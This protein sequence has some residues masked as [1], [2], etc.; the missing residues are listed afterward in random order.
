M[1]TFDDTGKLRSEKR[2]ERKTSEIAD[3]TRK[4]KKR[5]YLNSSCLKV[6]I[7]FEKTRKRSLEYTTY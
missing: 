7:K 3:Q 5:R 2:N 1:I 6:G 4:N